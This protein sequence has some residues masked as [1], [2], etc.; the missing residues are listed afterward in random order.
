MSSSSIYLGHQADEKL[1]GAYT[2]YAA[3]YLG[4]RVRRIIRSFGRAPEIRLSTQQTL[5]KR[6]CLKL[7]KRVVAVVMIY[8]IQPIL[9]GLLVEIRLGVL[10]RH[11]M[12]DSV[13]V[14]HLWDAW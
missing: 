13:P 12:S 11:G 5:I 9:W 1:V 2:S 14:I 4:N 3:I 6:L 7:V 10:V 8:L